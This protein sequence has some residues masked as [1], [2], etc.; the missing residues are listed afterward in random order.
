[1][2]PCR[3]RLRK[4]GSPEV[5]HCFREQNGVAGIMAKEDANS[6]DFGEVTIFEVLPVGAVNA[7]WTD[8]AGTFFE[9]RIKSCI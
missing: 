5:S 4:L 7:V 1:M 8:N 9:R 2:M 6:T 3:S